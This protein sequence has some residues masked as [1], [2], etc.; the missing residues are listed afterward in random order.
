LWQEEG[1]LV[2]LERLGLE[3]AHSRGRWKRVPFQPLWRPGRLARSFP[4][5]KRARIERSQGD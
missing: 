2:A 3:L 5:S 4:R 1:P